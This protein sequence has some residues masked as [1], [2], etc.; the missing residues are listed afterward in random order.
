MNF[1]RHIPPSPGGPVPRGS[2][3]EAFLAGLPHFL[4]GL[5][6]GLSPLLKIIG[7]DARFDVLQ[8]ILNTL[9]ALASLTSLI[10]LLRLGRPRWIAAWYLY[11]IPT[12]FYLI[13]A[14]WPGVP[15]WLEPYQW[16]S[17]PTVLTL[18][19]LCT[20]YLLYRI[21]ARDRLRAV[22][23]AVP[24]ILGLW[25]MNMVLFPPASQ[26]IGGLASSLLAALIC[27]AAVRLNRPAPG[28]ALVV[29]MTALAG[30][31]ITFL[32]IYLS[33][34]LPYSEPVPSLRAVWKFFSPLFGATAAL[35][36]GPQ[37]AVTLREL[38]QRSLPA[39]KPVYRLPLAGLLLS[40]AATVFV[41]ISSST[42]SNRQMSLLVPSYDVIIQI[43]FL[44]GM[45]FYVAGYFRLLLAMRRDPRAFSNPLLELLLFITLPGVPLALTGVIPSG[46]FDLILL[47]WI[48][49]GTYLSESLWRQFAVH[50]SF[51]WVLLSISAAIAWMKH[52]RS[53]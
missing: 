22:L 35:A 17:R 6:V 14:F 45:L 48:L 20:G 7:V 31:T 33:G 16:I 3:L 13:V 42:E 53:E 51:L 24:A 52:L 40:L 21:A 2:W 46:D 34:S 36:I 26:A 8:I 41:L 43:I 10:I 50:L 39:G 27:I 47:R 30:F 1:F 15:S 12:G 25:I 44:S 29:G 38:A 11:W 5:Y 32:G 23:T 4:F 49:D 37:L 28:L 9:F 18:L 19:F